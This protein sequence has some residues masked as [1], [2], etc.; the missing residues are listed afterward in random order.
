NGAPAQRL[1]FWVQVLGSDGAPESAAFQFPFPAGEARWVIVTA[2]PEGSPTPD[3]P[4]HP[5]QPL[6]TPDLQLDPRLAS[7]VNVKVQFAQLAPNTPYWKLIS[8]QYQDP[9]ESG[10]NVN[11]VVFVQDERGAAVTN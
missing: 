1:D 7:Q 6:P 11:I 4:D 8:A 9:D 3:N 10:G 5:D 2:A